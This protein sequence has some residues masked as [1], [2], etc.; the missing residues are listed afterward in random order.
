MTNQTRLGITSYAYDWA[1]S[2]PGNGRAPLSAFQLVEKASRHQLNVV[3]ICENLPLS[4][5]DPNELSHLKRY[6]HARDICLELGLR[7][8][9]PQG[10]AAG[11]EL[12]GKLE[13]RLVRL[14]PWSGNEIPQPI[15]GEEVFRKLEPFLPICRKEG[16]TLAIEN[17]FDLPDDALAAMLA[18]VADPFLGACLD[19]A[20]STGRLVD[21]L[22]TAQLLAP[23]IVS[24]HLK[25]FTVFKPRQGYRISGAPLGKGWLE[26]HAILEIIDPGNKNVPILIEHWIEREDPTKT[27][28]ETEEDWLSQSIE[29]A[30]QELDQFLNPIRSFK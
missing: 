29:F 23:F 18:Q 26:L 17:Y 3:Q 2:Q 13:A 6:A 30:R 19:T 12:A 21:P 4:K 20:N 7:G 5:L 10:L 24:V 15:S 11:L 22:E 14:V 25:D 27:I 16:I 1:I 8:L 28:L 9:D